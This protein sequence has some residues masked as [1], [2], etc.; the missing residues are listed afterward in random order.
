MNIDSG[1]IAA[2]ISAAVALAVGYM[3]RKLKAAETDK[4]A[5]EAWQS[6]IEPMRQRINELENGRTEDRKSILALE[7]TV[8]NL[9]FTVDAQNRTI[10][11][12]D[13]RINVLISYIDSIGGDVPDF[14]VPLPKA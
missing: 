2:F 5:A 9:Q 11:A 3:G 13:G 8:R 1:I 14:M 10:K 4:T 12:Q 6:L 7:A